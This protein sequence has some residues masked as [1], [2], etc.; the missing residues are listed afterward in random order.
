MTEA[1]IDHAPSTS[2]GP[3]EPLTG[4]R[5]IT[6]DFGNTL[7]RVS[8]ASLRAVVELA[9]ERSTAALGLGAPDAFLAA[10]HE[11]RERQFRDDLPRHREV[12]LHERAIRVLARLRGFGPPALDEPWDDTAA[13]TRSRP[14]EVEH[15][16]ESYSRAF[17]E[18][19]PPMDGATSV[20]EG[21]ATRG[22]R[23]AIL[24]NW[25]L[26]RTIDEY[27]A[28][29]G[30]ERHLAGIYVSQRIGTI[31]PQRQIFEV[32]AAGL[33]TPPAHL[34]HVGDDWAADVVGA[35]D[36]GWRVAY[37]RDHQVDTPLPTSDRA[38]GVQPD[39]E[40]DHL[41]ELPARVA[42]PIP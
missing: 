6:I 32:A 15:V 8:R 18:L 24:S 26:A 23:L 25:P 14:D 31:K 1:A 11:E 5:A 42:D 38:A 37:L 10:W 17:L 27:A 29:A 7:V 21:L 13:A 28:R 3:G 2:A 34:L 39:L 4:I 41:T 20:L 12:D 33:A 30:W 35:R 16:V 40:L 19:V 36:A 9:S 22:F